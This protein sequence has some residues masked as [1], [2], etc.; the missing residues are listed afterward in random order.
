MEYDYLLEAGLNFATC[1]S[2]NLV[3]L[4][5]RSWTDF[6][7]SVAFAVGCRTGRVY[8]AVGCLVALGDA[9]VGSLAG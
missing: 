8:T 7:T 4:M 3:D 1:L 9:G 5:P 2:S 6:G